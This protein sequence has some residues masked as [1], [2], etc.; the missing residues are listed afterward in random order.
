MIIVQYQTQKN[1]ADQS[2]PLSYD[3]VFNHVFKKL[4]DTFEKYR[5]ILPAID[6]VERAI[7]SQ[8]A[9]DPFQMTVDAI[10]M[11]KTHGE[12]SELVH[13]IFEN[14]KQDFWH[15]LEPELIAQH[16][17]KYYINSIAD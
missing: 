15:A 9:G 13:E 4:S 17:G 6:D 1:M 7:V 14:V 12:K 5:N 8:K 16:Q 11:L 3:Y 2:S 10:E